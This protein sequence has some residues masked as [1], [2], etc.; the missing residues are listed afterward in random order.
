MGGKKPHNSKRTLVCFGEKGVGS[1]SE[2]IFWVVLRRRC[3]FNLYNDM[4]KN[5]SYNQLWKQ[6]YYTFYLEE[7]LSAFT[8]GRMNLTEIGSICENC[9]IFEIYVKNKKNTVV[10]ELNWIRK[11]SWSWKTMEKAVQINC[12]SIHGRNRKNDSIKKTD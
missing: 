2:F 9:S 3:Y 11:C 7:N 8:T 6:K 5:T 1:E 12:Y 4:Q 10:Y